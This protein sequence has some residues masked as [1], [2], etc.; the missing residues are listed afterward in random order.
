[1]KVLEA[2]LLLA[3][4]VVITLFV[5]VAI[6]EPVWYFIVPSA[7]LTV[8]GGPSEGWLHVRR[9]DRGKIMFVTRRSGG[10]A[11][12]YMIVL[13]KGRQG[14]AWPCGDWT[15]PHFPLFPIGDVNPPC[16]FFTVA[17]QE[18][19][20]P[21]PKPVNRELRSGPDYVEF[22]ADDGKRIRASW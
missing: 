9:D 5:R 19:A 8:D 4:L 17:G 6:F 16:T 11:E 14:R 1:M 22:T 18:P 13:E 15:A 3:A 2:I 21:K 12:S 20:Q 7:R 10:K